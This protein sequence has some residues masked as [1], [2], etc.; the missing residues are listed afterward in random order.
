MQYPLAHEALPLLVR[1]GVLGSVV[2]TGVTWVWLP[3]I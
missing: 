1:G 3:N 2:G